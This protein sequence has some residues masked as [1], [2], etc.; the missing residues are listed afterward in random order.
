[1]PYPQKPENTPYPPPLG[2][3]PHPQ[4]CGNPTYSQPPINPAYPQLTRYP[5][6]SGYPSPNGINQNNIRNVQA[7]NVVV[8]QPSQ[9]QPLYLANK[10]DLNFT[11]AIVLSC[12]SFWLCG[13]LF[14]LI[15]F[16]LASEFHLLRINLK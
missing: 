14:G 4:S 11:G 15:A 13:G 3:S 7:P 9:V 5:Q 16:I 12:V 6:S 1:M 8:I 2:Y 10:T